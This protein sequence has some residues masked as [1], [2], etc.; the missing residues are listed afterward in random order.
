MAT[1][2]PIYLKQ[3]EYK[4]ISSETRWATPFYVMRRFSDGALGEV[5]Q[6]GKDGNTY[7]DGF[8]SDASR[9]FY[10]SDPAGG[11]GKVARLTVPAGGGGVNAFGGSITSH[12][13]T[14]KGDVAYFGCRMYVP[15]ALDWTAVQGT[16]TLRNK[17]LRVMNKRADGSQV[18]YN[19]LYILRDPSLHG[20]MQF[21][22][23]K[24]GQASWADVGDASNQF[25]RD[26]WE[27]YQ[28]AI[29]CDNIPVD[30]GGTG[31][32]EIFKNG[33]RIANITK[34]ETLSTA[35]GYLDFAKFFTLWDDAG[36]S[37]EQTLYLDDVFYTNVKPTT[38]DSTG[39]LRHEQ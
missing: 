32:V 6:N 10:A 13:R 19:D 4:Y 36:A 28:M 34:I 5:A 24:E 20:G 3:N 2:Q 9:S 16:V 38:T 25:V 39:N 8:D 33:E 12:R 22:F 30:Q 15:A 23:I 35:D 17:F 11:V 7:T 21:E 37:S 27:T 14:Y 1:A 26:T 18:G 29:H 31:R